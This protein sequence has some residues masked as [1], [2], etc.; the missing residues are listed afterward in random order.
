M[1]EISLSGSGG[2]PGKATTRGYPTLRPRLRLMFCEFA[3]V[4]CSPMVGSSDERV[5]TPGNS[6]SQPRASSMRNRTR[7]SVQNQE[8]FLCVDGTYIA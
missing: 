5:A 7:F 2:G 6:S 4:A 1:V 3:V 8:W